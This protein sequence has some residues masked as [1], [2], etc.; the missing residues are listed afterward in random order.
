[1]GTFDSMLCGGEE[2]QVHDHNITHRHGSR[3]KKLEL[4]VILQVM[5][6]SMATEQ[7][8]GLLCR[9]PRKNDT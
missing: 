9:H 3:R 1:M 2:Q 5:A 6:R 4:Q 7:Q 8:Q